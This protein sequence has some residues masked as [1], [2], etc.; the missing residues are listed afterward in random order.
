MK[1]P[2]RVIAFTVCVIVVL[3]I[4]LWFGLGRT[5]LPEE[6]PIVAAWIL[7]HYTIHAQKHGYAVDGRRPHLNLVICDELIDDTSSKE[8]YSSALSKYDVSLFTESEAPNP[9]LESDIEDW[10]NGGYQLFCTE[11]VVNSPLVGRLESATW[12]GGLGANGF[13]SWFIFVFGKWVHVKSY[14]AWVS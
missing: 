1:S 9:D 4:L 2:T 13:D 14:Q 3:Q 7:E 8:K 6:G 11:P 10:I 5:S 12:W